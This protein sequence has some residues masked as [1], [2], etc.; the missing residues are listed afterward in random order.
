MYNL[1]IIYFKR[2]KICNFIKINQATTYQ[3]NIFLKERRKKNH[4]N[5]I[6][7]KYRNKVLSLQTIIDKD[8][9]FEGFFLLRKYLISLAEGKIQNYSKLRKL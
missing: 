9:S 4:S 8:F 2:N 3:G 5:V 1:I 6:Y 7:L